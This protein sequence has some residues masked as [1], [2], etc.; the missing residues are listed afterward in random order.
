VILKNDCSTC[1][2]FVQEPPTYWEAISCSTIPAV[3]EIDSE[4][5]DGIGSG[6]G[7][8]DGNVDTGSQCDE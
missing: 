7:G 2:V 4:P 5:M 6:S 8:N 1:V 3:T